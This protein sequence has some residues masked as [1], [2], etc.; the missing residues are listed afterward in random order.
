MTGSYLIRHLLPPT[1]GLLLALGILLLNKEGLTSLGHPGCVAVVL[2]FSAACWFL[3][4][5]RTSLGKRERPQCSRIWKAIAPLAAF[6]AGPAS[7]AFFWVLEVYVF[8]KDLYITS[9]ERIDQL[10]AAMPIGVLVGLAASMI[11]F[12][13]T[14]SSKEEERE[15]ERNHEDDQ[16]E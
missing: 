4:R 13:W 5:P 11:V 14:V 8:S 2:V 1:L 16:V 15:Q 6:F 7:V 3:F 12:V 9:Y 10:M